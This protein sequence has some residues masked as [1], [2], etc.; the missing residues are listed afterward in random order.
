[1]KLKAAERNLLFRLS[2]LAA[3]ERVRLYMVGGIV[4]E[5]LCGNAQ[6]DF[7]LDLIVEGDAHKFASVAEAVLGGKLRIFEK[8]LTAKICEISGFGGISEVD[9]AS[10]R[11][12]SYPRPG[13]LPV[14]VASTIEDDLRRRDFTMNALCV[15]LPQFLETVASDGSPDLDRLRGAVIDQF[16]GIADLAAR[17]VRVLHDRSFIDDPTRIFRGARYAARL[18]GIF[19]AETE[20]LLCSAVAGGALLTVS[21]F[22]V[23]Q[24]LRKVLGE[25]Q[26]SAALRLLDRYGVLHAAQLLAPGSEPVRR[27]QEALPAIDQLRTLLPEEQLLNVTM[28]FLAELNPRKTEFLTRNEVGRRRLAALEK[29]RESGG[30]SDPEAISLMYL[31]DPRNAELLK[32]L[33]TCSTGGGKRG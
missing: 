24:E 10:A 15:E 5:M 2:S 9:F 20:Q 19:A 4:R 12:E 31:L 6:F 27:W 8:F 13:A 14:V 32:R 26:P 30:G 7:D 17:T 3:A 16:G 29:Q 23:R 11:R 25:Q 28:F 21:A 33:A 22:R 18:S 1:M